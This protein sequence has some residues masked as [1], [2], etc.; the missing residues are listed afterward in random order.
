MS[1]KRYSL[2]DIRKIVCE[3]FTPPLNKGVQSATHRYTATELLP[4]LHRI[5]N[6]KFSLHRLGYA[7]QAMDIE[8]IRDHSTGTRY[9]YLSP[10]CIDG[11]EDFINPLRQTP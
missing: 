5:S 7:L 4:V 3:V 6:N 9:F 8:P 1:S 2:H 11:H 10:R